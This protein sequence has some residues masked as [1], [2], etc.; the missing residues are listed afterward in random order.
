MLCALSTIAATTKV[1]LAACFF[2]SSDL[3]DGNREIV[4]TNNGLTRMMKL[5]WQRI[6]PN[7]IVPTLYNICVAYGPGA[8]Q[9]VDWKVGSPV[10]HT[11]SS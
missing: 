1:S 10:P 5:A 7:L 9:L 2:V 8:K 11:S 3:A 6:E 4:L